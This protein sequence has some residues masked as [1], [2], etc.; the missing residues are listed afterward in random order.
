MDL[1]KNYSKI[2]DSSGWVSWPLAD[3][4]DDCNEPAGSVTDR[5]VHL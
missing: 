1:K 4:C 2:V 5:A 3:C